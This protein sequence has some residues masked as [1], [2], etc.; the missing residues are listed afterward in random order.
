MVSRVAAAFRENHL[1]LY[2]S[3]IAFQV[4]TALA[5]LLLF[6][7]ALAGV[8][9]L[10][11]LWRGELSETVA[12]Q[13]SPTA[14]ALIDQT[15]HDV[16]THKRVVW[17][18]LGA[19]LAIWQLSGAV[20]ASMAALDRIRGTERR[21]FKEVVGRSLWLAAAG[22]A[23]VFAAM[24][25]VVGGP[26][27]VGDLP[28]GLG[29]LFFLARW[30]VAGALLL[31]AVGLLVH[32][33]PERRSDAAWTSV[34]SLLVVVAWALTSIA[35]GAYLS[36]AGGTLFGHLVTVVVLIGYLYGASLAFMIGA[37][38]D[39]VLTAAAAGAARG[40]RR[41]GRSGRFRRPARRAAR[42]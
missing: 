23:L 24:A 7:M 13:V 16:L 31:A 39:A 15:V 11:E 36:V 35:F 42:R 14:F 8:L 38:A 26:L 18:T 41:R 27:V 6:G 28:A 40:R 5:P 22:T 21:P 17:V 25:V 12:E 1:S 30:A 33:G 19:V 4:L 29:V 37:Q 32:F 20:R 10:D 2:A 3:A 34:G 9:S